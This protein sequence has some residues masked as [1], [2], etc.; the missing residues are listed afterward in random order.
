MIDIQPTALFTIEDTEIQDLNGGIRKKFTSLSASPVTYT[1]IYDPTIFR[2]DFGDGTPIYETN[3]RVTYHTYRVAG[4]YLVK[5][6]A[7]NFCA[8]SDWSTCSQSIIV[9]YNFSSLA[10]ASILGFLIFKGTDC[11]DRKTKKSCDVLRDYCQWVDK[12]KKCVRKCNEGYKLEKE[13]TEDIKRPYRSKCVLSKE[14][15]KLSK[16]EHK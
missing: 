13:R 4:T 10:I 15:S 16:E 5:H 14:R 3:D 2:W 11:E 12:E 9:E 7:C 6:Q 8:C 1:D